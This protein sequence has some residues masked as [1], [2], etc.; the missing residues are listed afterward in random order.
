MHHQF[1]PTHYHRSL[2]TYEPVLRVNSG[3]SISTTTVDAAGC[4][5]T[6]ATVTPRGNPQTGPFLV[7]GALPG[8]SLVVRIDQIRPNR[9]SGWARSVVA[10]NCVDPAFVNQIPDGPFAEWSINHNEGT[11]TLI[12]PSSK[13][14]HLTIPIEPMLGCFGVAP[15]RQQAISTAT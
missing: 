9:N 13:L 4:D 2:G 1:T 6:G 12:S 15:F 8:D 5:Q 10:P 7:E 14:G 11:A 3:D